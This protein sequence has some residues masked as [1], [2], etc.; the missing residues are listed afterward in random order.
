MA[1]P[2][3]L[4]LEATNLPPPCTGPFRLLLHGSPSSGVA[5][6]LERL[7][8]ES[9]AARR[10][11]LLSDAAQPGHW[12]A[13]LADALPTVP[14]VVV[15]AH[16]GLDA[17]AH[18]LALVASL[19]GAR[20][21]VLVVNRMARID[22]REDA[23]ARLV[24]RYRNYCERIGIVRLLAV[25]VDA[26]TGDNLHQRSARLPW[27]RDKPLFERLEGCAPAATQ[28]PLRLRAL[29]CDATQSLPHCARLLAGTPHLGD[30]VVVLPD[31]A[32]SRLSRLQYIESPVG[33]LLRFALEPALSV[34]P[35][36]LITTPQARPEVADQFAAHLLW[37]DEQPLYPGRRYLLRQGETLVGAR[38][39][40]IKHRLQ[41]DSLERHAAKRLIRNDLG[42]CNLALDCP[43]PFDPSAE[44]PATGTFQL[45]DHDS[46]ATIACGMVAFGLR[47]AANIHRHA[48]K[49]D[50]ACRAAA[51]A[52][53]P[54]VLWFT[55]LS[56]SGKSTVADLVEQRLQ[57]LGKR[58][59][60][61]D[62]D[63]VRHGLNRDLGF[64]NEDRVENIRRIGEVAKLMVEAGLITLVSFISPFRSERQTV[65]E[66]LE[67][68][69]FVEI[70]V[71]ASLQTCETRDPKGLYKKARAG[72]LPNFTGIGS[73]YEAPQSPD[74]RLPADDEDA[75][76]LAERVI[77]H[78][79]Q[80]A[81]V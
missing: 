12:F 71:D 33:P 30:E 70:F 23:F 24:R 22:W 17:E 6:L 61:L 16:T 36:D 43:L 37:L 51:N 27:Y 45:L 35:G 58:T 78:L 18:R 28:Q 25:P 80:R 64:T 81:I 62:G 44:R 55:G 60:L 48:M 76:R 31:A 38:V 3:P 26:E 52:Q 72:Q 11:M 32:P 19:L 66:L 1:R 29:P 40:E 7:R 50:K 34:S 69:E 63:N 67:A 56:G 9:D 46:Q 10:R 4:R 39:T 59:M 8:H 79:R 14:V 2:D 57:A 75:E 5:P 21:L 65:R 42:F 41:P 74:L 49:V 54:C 53:Q 47:R 13:Q 73:P 20:Q 15:D 77:D 68:D